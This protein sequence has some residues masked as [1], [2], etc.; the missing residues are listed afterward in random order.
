[1]PHSDWKED[2]VDV[3]FS[4]EKCEEDKSQNYKGLNVFLERIGWLVILLSVISKKDG[5]PKKNQL[6]SIKW[7]KEMKLAAF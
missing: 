7:M 1:M 5:D 4:C 2:F 6:L 3:L